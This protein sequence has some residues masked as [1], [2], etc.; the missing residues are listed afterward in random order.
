MMDNFLM[1]FIAVVF[2]FVLFTL[3]I[4]FPRAMYTNSH[5]LEKG[6]A[7]SRTTVTGKGYCIARDYN[8]REYSIPLKGAP[9]N[10]VP[11]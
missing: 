2:G 6:Y 11:K 5:C 4:A 3:F 9:N 7:S 10:P 1:G 8:G